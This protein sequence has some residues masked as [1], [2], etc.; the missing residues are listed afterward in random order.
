M[1]CFAF[2][3]ALCTVS[4]LQDLPGNTATNA[5]LVNER[6]KYAFNVHIEYKMLLNQDNYN[7]LNCFVSS[8]SL[9]RGFQGPVLEFLIFLKISKITLKV[10][11]NI[12]YYHY[13]PL[14]YS[15]IL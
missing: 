2:S 1:L 15:F 14:K 4:A 6:M 12:I 5:L 13:I 9:H 11:K 3:G 8:L 7:V 10:Y